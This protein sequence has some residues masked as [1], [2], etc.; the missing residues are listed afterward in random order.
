MGKQSSKE[1]PF[2]TLSNSSRDTGPMLS[3][4]SP[5]FNLKPQVFITTDASDSGWGAAVDNRVMDGVWSPSQM[6]WHI[7]LKELYSV[8]R[9]LEMNLDLVQGKSVLVQSD[10]RT[11]VAYVRREGGTKSLPLIKE[12]ENT[13]QIVQN[14]KISLEANFIPGV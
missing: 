8:R 9:A 3:V 4:P 11:V 6:K 2:S 12:T 1:S 7:N 13:F 14:H 10:N 5:I